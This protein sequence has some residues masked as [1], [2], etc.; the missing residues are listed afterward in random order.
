MSLT[1]P[2]SAMRRHHEHHA[3]DHIG[4]L[5]AAVLGANDGIIS[6]ASLIVGVASAGPGRSAILLAGG[7]GL[8]AGALSMAAG[9]YISVSSQADLEQADLAR[10]A[11]ELH[12]NPHGEELEL[13]GI[14]KKRGVSSETAHAVA[15]ELMAH[16]ALDAHARD[17]LGLSDATTARPVQAAVASAACFSAGAALPLLTAIVAPTGWVPHIVLLSSI[18]VLAVLGAVSARTGGAPVA[19]AIVRVTSLGAAAMLLTI[20]LGRLFGAV[21]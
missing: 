20:G 19:K 17:E 4:W 9:E 10:E 7:A 11:I 8:I 18:M 5:R 1:K 16:D 6:T 14:Y 13:A 2:S 15:R 3:T 21:F 12:A